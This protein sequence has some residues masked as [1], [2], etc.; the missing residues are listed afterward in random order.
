MRRGNRACWKACL[1]ERRLKAPARAVMFES[2][3][4]EA[5]EA[6]DD[7]QRK[8]S[9]A[10]P[11]LP[12]GKDGLPSALAVLTKAYPLDH[13]KGAE[14]ARREVKEVSQSPRPAEEPAFHKKRRD[15]GDEAD[16][17][18]MVAEAKR[19]GRL[20]RAREREKA[21]EARKKPAYERESA[22]GKK[23]VLS[24]GPSSL[25]S[26]LRTTFSRIPSSKAKM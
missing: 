17:Q 20:I 8:P 23:I 16:E 2:S 15:V 5:E 24:V 18:R 10:V 12:C 14:A 7:R 1:G 13:F 22:H 6:E 26:N 21:E 9:P 25:P 19:R 3:S 11:V 4:S